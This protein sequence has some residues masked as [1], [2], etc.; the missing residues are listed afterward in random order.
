MQY[1]VKLL[2]LGSKPPALLFGFC[3]PTEQP[4]RSW[5]RKELDKKL[6]LLQ[7]TAILNQPEKDRLLDIFDAK[8]SLIIDKER[9][10][11]NLKSRPSV[12]SGTSGLEWENNYEEISR[13][14]MTGI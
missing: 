14:F 1:F 8:S 2:L 5:Q 10:T 12:F 6:Y 4:F 11:F 9:L 7:Y 13:R 3:A